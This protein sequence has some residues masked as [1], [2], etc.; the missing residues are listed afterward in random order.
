MNKFGAIA[1]PMAVALLAACGTSNQANPALEQARNAF[2][3]AA[4]DPQVASN[5]TLDLRN[6]EA[7]LRRAEAAQADG[8]TEE[9]NHQAYITSQQVAVARENARYAQAR[10][11]VSNA[12]T[13]RAQ[14]RAS[15]LE[16]QLAELQA[17]QTDRGMVVAVSDVLFATGQSELMPGAENELAR[18]GQVLRDNPEQTIVVEGYTDSTGSSATNLRLSEARAEAVREALVRYGADPRRITIRG[19]G[20]ANPVASNATA[21]GRQAN[22]RVEVV[23]NEDTASQS[24]PGRTMQ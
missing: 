3:G 18:L 15:S 11:T 23:L 2:Q 5:A 14:A 17:K 7:S 9:A 6:A 8:D 19:M 24:A 12:D 20:S 16:Q 10:S 1:L 13:A 4:A 21:A 22:R